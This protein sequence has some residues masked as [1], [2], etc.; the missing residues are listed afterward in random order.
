MVPCGIM[1]DFFSSSLET[2]RCSNTSL[3]ESTS[4]NSSMNEKRR[5]S[6]S[7]FFSQTKSVVNPSSFAPFSTCSAQ[8][9]PNVAIDVISMSSMR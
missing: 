3:K 4:I 9:E 8:C 1:T 7:R 6:F 5:Y 2:H